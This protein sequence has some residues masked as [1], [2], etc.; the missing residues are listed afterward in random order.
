MS[1]VCHVDLPLMVGHASRWTMICCICVC[2]RWIRHKSH[3]RIL[4][5]CH[6]TTPATPDPRSLFPTLFHTRA[7]PPDALMQMQPH[8]TKPPEFRILHAD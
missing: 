1:I 6:L 7:V 2:F 8:P 4:Q 3:P 5:K